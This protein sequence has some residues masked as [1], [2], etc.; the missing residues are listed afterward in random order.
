MRDV[1]PVLLEEVWAL[2]VDV[3]GGLLAHAR[4]VVDQRLLVRLREAEL[5]R[6]AEHAPELGLVGRRLR[7]VSRAR[8]QD[9]LVGG[10]REVLQSLGAPYFVDDEAQSRARGLERDAAVLLP[11]VEQRLDA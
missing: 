8:V 3:F 4:H 9:L 6:L 5:A 1:A 2:G 10:R 7:L 11:S